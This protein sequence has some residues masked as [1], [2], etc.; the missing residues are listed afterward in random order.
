[1]LQALENGTEDAC[2]LEAYRENRLVRVREH[3]GLEMWLRQ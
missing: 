2:I 1:M 3:M